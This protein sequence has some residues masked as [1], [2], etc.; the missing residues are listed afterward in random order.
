MGRLASHAFPRQIARWKIRFIGGH[1]APQTPILGGPYARVSL[2]RSPESLLI[3]QFCYVFKH[4][5]EGA[6]YHRFFSQ[7]AAKDVFDADDLWAYFR[8][9]GDDN[10]QMRFYANLPLGGLTRR[11]LDEA[12]AALKSMAFVGTQDEMRASIDAFRILFGIA[13]RQFC[14]YNSSDKDIVKLTALERAELAEK[15]MPYDNELY[16]YGHAIA[17]EHRRAVA[18]LEPPGGPTVMVA[19]EKPRSLNSAIHRALHKDLSEWREFGSKRVGR[20][21]RGVAPRRP[22]AQI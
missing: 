9:L 22:A 17:L 13:H 12:L 20:F 4:R 6:D 10:L 18:H 19:D 11:H 21:F 3:S 14:H 8:E 7:R 5:F 16:H 15:L 1:I 2:L